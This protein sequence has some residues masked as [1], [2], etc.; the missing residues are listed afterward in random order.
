MPVRSTVRSPTRDIVVHSDSVCVRSERSGLFDIGRRYELQVVAVD[1][2]GN[3]S[4]PATTAI[5]V[6]HDQSK[7]DRCAFAGGT[8]V[9][10]DD[11]RCSPVNALP[12]GRIGT[13][14]GGGCSTGEPAGLLAALGFLAVLRRRR[15]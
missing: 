10:D 3:T 14:S 15:R 12:S 5:T 11:P 1:A 6:P 13:Q 2:A 7:L 8:A 4:Q 9:D